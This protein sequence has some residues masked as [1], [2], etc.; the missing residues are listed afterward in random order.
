M[1]GDIDNQ[2]EKV[3]KLNR[4]GWLVDKYTQSRSLGIWVS[5]AVSAINV[6]LVLGSMQL[7]V[8]LACRGSWWWWAPVVGAFVWGLT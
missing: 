1:S 2:K 7:C 6:I 5:V 8:F 3:E 4:L